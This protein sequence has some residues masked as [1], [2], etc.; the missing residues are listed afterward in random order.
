MGPYLPGLV[1]DSACT[2]DGIL[3]TRGLYLMMDVPMGPYL[4]GLAQWQ[5]MMG[6]YL[7]DG[8]CKFRW[9]FV[10]SGLYL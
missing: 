3:F 5:C 8:W 2:Y 10:C 7:Y 4:P 9:D 6:P 1:F